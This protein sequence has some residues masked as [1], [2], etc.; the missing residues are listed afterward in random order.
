MDIQ[1]NE[2]LVAEIEEFKKECLKM[3][4]VEVLADSYTNTNLFDY[5][6]VEDGKVWW[7]KTQA[8]QLWRFW[9]ASKAEAVLQWID[10]N[11]RMPE[12]GQKVLT[13]RPFAHEKPHGDPNIKI[14]TYCGEGLWIN[15]HFEHVITHWM[16]L[17]SPP[18][19]LP[20]I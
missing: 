2:A 10:V 7:M 16:S 11:E 4:I 20:F 9:N 8:Y 12:Q 15:S 14:A 19:E 5:I 3:Y 18:E 6:I 13:Y 1:K 17:I